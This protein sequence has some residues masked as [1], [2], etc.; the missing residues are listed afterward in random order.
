MSH[1][2]GTSQLSIPVFEVPV[3]LE[4][5]NDAELRCQ[6]VIDARDTWAP[7]VKWW[8]TPLYD[9]E[10]TQKLVYQRL[11]ANDATVLGQ[12]HNVGKY[13]FFCYFEAKSFKTL[14]FY[15]VCYKN[16]DCALS[17]RYHIAW[18]GDRSSFL[19]SS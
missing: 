1:V 17:Y 2:V 12:H 18:V 4:V 9:L 11:G 7:Y 15:D 16:A 10:K 3:S 19:S 5:G 8:W 14:L 6:F 13:F